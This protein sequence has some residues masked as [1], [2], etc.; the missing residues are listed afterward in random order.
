MGGLQSKSGEEEQMGPMASV[1]LRNDGVSGEGGFERSFEH[2]M[3]LLV[4][5]T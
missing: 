3:D 2:R 1:Q 5:Y 4:G